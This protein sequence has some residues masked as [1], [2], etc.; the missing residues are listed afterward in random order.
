MVQTLL[1][2][3]NFALTF[4]QYAPMQAGLGGE[5]AVS[6]ASMVR[7][8]LLN[9]GVGPWFFNRN[10]TTIALTTSAQDYTETIADF[11]FIE[12]CTVV[13]D[14]NNAFELKDVYNNKPL[15]LNNEVLR[16]AAISVESNDGTTQI[17]RFS[18]IPDKTYTATIIYQMKAQLF[19]PYFISAASN[20]SGGNTTYTGI[21]DPLSFPTGATA[22]ITG[23]V[24]NPANNGSFTVVSSS[25]TTLVLANAAG[26]AETIS[27]YASNYSW[28][29]IPDYY[30]DIYNNLFL[31][32]ALAM[33]DD[34]RAQAYR[35]RGVAAFLAKAQG[36]SDTQKNVF[37]EQWLARGRQSA[38]SALSVQQGTGARA[39]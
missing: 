1:N 39:S 26:V 29:P 25:A 12:K 7:S 19:G 17:F 28:A 4:I 37:V 32:E 5:P 30:N 33:V 38:A 3:L 22:V 8:S 31:S 9:P 15:S 16:P 14:Q 11:G 10:T 24:T 27:A 2:T 34:A 23:F 6:I 20:V 21:F 13:D 35:A 36:L 18:G